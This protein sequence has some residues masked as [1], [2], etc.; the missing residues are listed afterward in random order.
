M[1]KDYF[2]DGVSGKFEG[3]DVVLPQDYDRYLTVM[4]GDYMTP[5]PPEKRIGHHYYTI[6]DM[7]KSYKEYI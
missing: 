3:L 6:A 2:G 1:L 5:P 7:D 4:Y